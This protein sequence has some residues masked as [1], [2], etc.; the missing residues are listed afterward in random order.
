MAKENRTTVLD[1][2]VGRGEVYANFEL[3]GAG[4]GVRPELPVRD[5]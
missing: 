5:G 3:A 4:R 2:G 1:W